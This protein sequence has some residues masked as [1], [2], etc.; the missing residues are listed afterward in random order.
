LPF[1]S[2]GIT[3]P[4]NRSQAAN[5]LNSLLRSFKRNPQLEKDY[6]TF[7]GKVLHRGH[8]PRYHLTS[9]ELLTDVGKSGTCRTSQCIIHENPAKFAWF[10]IPKQNTRECR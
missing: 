7:M 10:S 3:M 2:N 6:F 8:A 9:W 4:N 1:R 5:R